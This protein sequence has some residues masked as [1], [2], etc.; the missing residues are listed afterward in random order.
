MTEI[1]FAD[2]TIRDGNTSVWAQAM[3]TGMMLAIAP[4][5]D[6]FE[7]RADA[8]PRASV[9]PASDCF[10]HFFWLDACLG[11]K[12]DCFGHRLLD[13]QRNLVVDQLRHFASADLA[14]IRDLVADGA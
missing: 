14:D 11:A 8:A 5:L 4:E 10:E 1:R 2:T 13:H 3:R 7:L 6:R 12:R 9:R